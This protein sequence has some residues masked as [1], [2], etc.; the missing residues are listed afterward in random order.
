MAYMILQKEP[1]QYWLWPGAVL[2]VLYCGMVTFLLF[3]AVSATSSLV[4]W[5]VLQALQFVFIFVL[6]KAYWSDFKYDN[7]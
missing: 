4:F 5:K 2:I 7:K 3:G 1:F 6:E